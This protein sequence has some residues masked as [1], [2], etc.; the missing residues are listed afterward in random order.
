MSRIQ[1]IDSTPSYISI[2]LKQHMDQLLDICESGIKENGSG[3][4]GFKCSEKDNKMDVF[5]MNE[6]SILMNISK[7]SWEQLQKSMNDKKL[8]FIQDL[9]IQSIFLVYI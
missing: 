6:E 4:L 1:N 9:D 3:C 8:F 7:E 5:F 2:F